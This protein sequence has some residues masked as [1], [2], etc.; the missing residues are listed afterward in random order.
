M[1]AGELGKVCMEVLKCRE[2][3]RGEWRHNYS[4]ASP[5]WL[6]RRNSLYNFKKG[7]FGLKLN[8]NIFSLNSNIPKRYKELKERPIE[9]VSAFIVLG[10]LYK[11]DGS[12]ACLFLE[13]RSS[14]MSHLNDTENHSQAVLGVSV[15][16]TSIFFFC[17]GFGF[18]F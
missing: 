9:M 11:Y 13:L 14:L 1:F 10:A 4:S 17:F 12:F 5:L 18:F 2:G 3:A 16:I 15:N 8:F 6:L 7:V